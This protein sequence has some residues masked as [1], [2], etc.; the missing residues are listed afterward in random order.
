MARPINQNSNTGWTLR[1]DTVTLNAPGAGMIAGADNTLKHNC[2]TLNGQYGFQSSDVN[3]WGVDS[4]TGGPYNVTIEDNEIS[5]N[6]TCDFEGPLTN[7]AIGW[8]NYNPVPARYRNPHCGA[9]NAGRQR[10][11]LQALADRRRDR[12]RTTTS[13]TTG[14]R[15]SGRTRTTRT[16]RTPAT[17]SPTTTAQAI[18]EEISYNFSITNNYLADNGWADGLGNPG[19]PSPAIYVSQS[20][21]DTMFG[22]VPACPEASCSGQGSYTSQSVISGNTFVNNGGNVF[23]WQNSDRFC[24]A[25]FDN[26][27]TLVDGGELGA[28]HD[29]RLQGQ[30]PVGVDQHDHVCTRAHRAA[31]AGLVGRLH[32]VDR[33]REG[34]QEHHRL[35]PGGNR[36]LQQDCLARLRGRRDFRANTASPPPYNQPGAGP[37]LSQVTFFRE[38]HLVGQCLQRP[39]DLLRLEPGQRRQSGQLGRLD[40]S[41]CRRATSAVR[42]VTVRAEPAPARSARTREARTTAVRCHRRPPRPSRRSPTAR[43]GS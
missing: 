20:G 5:Y 34:H 15:A 17:R 6:D 12:S 31:I 33:E 43:H 10:G 2:L 23:L 24:S 19:F 30:P 18:I 16:R 32:V 28:V 35:Q 29:V 13:T 27:C 37:I 8:S 11:R 9:V 21:S 38:R 7:T 1:Y 22:G 36:A 3:S 25:G 41:R 4:L 14:A 40:R 42:L 26:A 39:V